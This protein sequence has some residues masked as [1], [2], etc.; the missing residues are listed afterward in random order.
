M[1][2]ELD[3]LVLK[4]KEGDI[5]SKGEILKR[6]KGLVINSIKRYYNVSNEY[7][8][9]VQ[10]GNIIILECINSYDE[11]LGAYFLGYVKTRL[12]YNYLDKH[13][14][15][16]HTSLNTD[17]GNEDHDELL[18]LLESEDPN[19]LEEY[20]E[21]EKLSELQERLSKLTYRQKEIIIYF[22]YEN[23]SIGDIAKKLG[24]TYRTIVNTKTRALEKMR[25][26]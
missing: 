26:L 19:P 6:L 5:E 3:R 12:K 22:Y 23:M 11:N 8:D 15:I 14:E 7:D 21:T 25:G 17:S 10:E 13:K 9:L 20:L 16:K 4:A 18:D 1:Y 2:K 24:I